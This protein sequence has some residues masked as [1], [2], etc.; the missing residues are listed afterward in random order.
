MKELTR[1]MLPHQID[2]VRQSLASTDQYEPSNIASMPILTS[3]PHAQLTLSSLLHV[4][5]S[6]DGGEVKYIRELLEKMYGC[7]INCY[8]GMIAQLAMNDMIAIANSKA[9]FGVCFFVIA[10]LYNACTEV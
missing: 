7:T 3:R 8:D 10:W 2:V 4:I 9:V 5:R 6:N 1:Q